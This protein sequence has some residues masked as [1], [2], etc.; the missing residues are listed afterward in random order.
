MESQ[1]ISG[2][3]LLCEQG[4]KMYYAGEI[5]WRDSDHASL[6]HK[7]T[8]SSKEG[9]LLLEIYQLYSRERGIQRHETKN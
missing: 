2:K 9:E 3:S 1:I 7:F 4:Q 8:V 5:E 6:P